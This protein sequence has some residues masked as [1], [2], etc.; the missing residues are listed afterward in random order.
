MLNI[1]PFFPPRHA[2]LPTNWLWHTILSSQ[3]HGVPMRWQG[4]ISL[5][6]FLRGTLHFLSNFIFPKK[7]FHLHF[8]RDGPPVSVGTA[9]GSGWMQE[10]FPAFLRHFQAHTRS[11]PQARVLLILDNHHHHK[12]TCRL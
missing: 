7:N 6:A 4:Q 5:L 8:V 2:S 9:N 11:S 12:C 1:Q 10:H 3:L